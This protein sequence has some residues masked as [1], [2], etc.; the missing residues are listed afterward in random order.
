MAK[1][2][3]LACALTLPLIGCVT[4]HNAQIATSEPFVIDSETYQA[5]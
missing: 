3:F 4:T 5:T 1:N 2:I